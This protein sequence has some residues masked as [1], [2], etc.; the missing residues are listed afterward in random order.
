MKKAAIFSVYMGSL[1]SYHQFTLETMHFNQSYDWFILTDQV[2]EEKR[3]GNVA[4]IP[5]EK[6]DL[7]KDLTE[8][9]SAKISLSSPRKIADTKVCWGELF[10]KRSES[11]P[12]FGFTDLDCIYG[13]IDRHVGEALETHDV[14]TQITGQDKLHGP[15]SLFRN[16][17]R[18]RRIYAEIDGLA[19][20][21]N[22]TCATEG[23]FAIEERFLPALIRQMGLRVCLSRTTHGPQLPLVRYGKRRTPAL[24]KNGEIVL[25]TYMEDYD[26]PCSEED[27]TSM[28]FHI[29]PNH[30]VD[31][32]NKRIVSTNDMLVTDYAAAGVAIPDSQVFRNHY[33]AIWEFLPLAHALVGKQLFVEV[34]DAVVLQEMAGKFGI[35][36][37]VSNAEPPADSATLLRKIKP[38]AVSF[39][40]IRSMRSTLATK[41]GLPKKIIITRRARFLSPELLGVLKEKGF[42]EVRLEEHDLLEQANLFYNAEMIV[43]NHG[44]SL[45]NIIFADVKKTKVLELNSGFNPTC[46]TR[47]DNQLVLMLESCPNRFNILFE[48]DIAE[49]AIARPDG[50]SNSEWH[51]QFIHTTKQWN[52]QFHFAGRR[53]FIPKADDFQPLKQ[54]NFEMDSERFRQRLEE[55]EQYSLAGCG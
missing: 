6:K 47:I 4:Y 49:R 2:D 35:D 37:K 45:A 18:I 43:A 8:L 31:S 40:F 24:W 15:F 23:I 46:Y 36:A 30:E 12:W 21:I 17:E 52:E 19:A 22:G 25:A 41:E 7:E 28:F 13:N 53:F 48:D 14:I 10:K 32:I 1:P 11:Y 27:A 33:H 55:F 16:E 34:V 29:R 38:P 42:T 54:K 44:A 51:T 3:M 39:S 5:Y 9:L 50:S 20:L 26:A